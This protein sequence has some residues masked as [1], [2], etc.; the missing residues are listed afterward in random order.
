MRCAAGAGDD[1]F[2]AALARG[3]GVFEQQVRRAMCRDDARFERRRRA[4][5][6]VSAA[7]CSVS[8]S[9]FEP[10]MMPTSGFMRADCSRASA[11]SGWAAEARAATGESG[12]RSS[13]NSS[14]A[15]CGAR[16]A[17][18]SLRARDR[19]AVDGVAHRR[20]GTSA[21]KLR[22]RAWRLPAAAD[23]ATARCDGSAMLRRAHARASRRAR[24]GS[25]RRRSCASACRC[26]ASA[27]TG[28]RAR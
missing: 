21:R 10:M 12:S 1:D 11:P 13:W 8:Q 25:A 16:R 26:T 9:D 15:A 24:R 3:A 18:R 23:R 22:D 28:R 17:A 5:C 6:S 20:S 7:G 2:E 27:G 4:R 19:R 14:R